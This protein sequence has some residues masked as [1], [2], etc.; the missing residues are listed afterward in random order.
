[1]DRDEGQDHRADGEDQGNQP[2]EHLGSCRRLSVALA[3]RS[4]V[5]R[6]RL[7]RAMP[8]TLLWQREGI[9]RQNDD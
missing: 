4:A 3:D 5:F 6:E 8:F 7:N 9:E 1:M 2:K